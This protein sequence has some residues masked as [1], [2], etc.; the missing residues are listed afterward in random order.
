MKTINLRDFIRTG[1]FGNITIGSKKADIIRELGKDYS[2]DDA[3][4]TQIISYGWYEF[5]FWTET[6]LVFG[7]QNDH[8]Q[9]DCINHKEMIN[10]KSKLWNVDKWFLHD[11]RNI[12]FGQVEKFLTRE[13]IAFEIVPTYHGCDENVIRCS[14]SNVTFD[15]VK[16][17]SVTE[18]DDNGKFKAWKEHIEEKQ[19]NYILNGIRLFNL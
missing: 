6:T 16:E 4:E 1:Y 3:G 9:A 11:D 10:Y 13:K 8:L 14:K 15:F 7:I 18:P 5:F 12:T 2:F 19:S 17:Y